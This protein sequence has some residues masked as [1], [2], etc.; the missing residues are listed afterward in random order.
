METTF[1][2]RYVAEVSLAEAL[3][4]NIVAVC[5]KRAT[6]EKYLINHAKGL[7]GTGPNRRPRV[8][9][10]RAASWRAG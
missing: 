7:E 10:S 3:S 5:A 8:L 2:C 9:I 4:P 1:A 6:G